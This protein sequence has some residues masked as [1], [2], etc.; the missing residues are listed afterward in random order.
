MYEPVTTVASFDSAPNSQRADQVML[1]A[2]L[3][4]AASRCS[5]V[6]AVR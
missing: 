5:S 4:C 3:T 1:V 2:I 6:Q